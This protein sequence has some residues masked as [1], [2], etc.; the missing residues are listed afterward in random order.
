[1]AGLPRDGALALVGGGQ[2]GHHAAQ[3]RQDSPQVLLE[4]GGLFKLRLCNFKL[5]PFKQETC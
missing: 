1:M 2:Q 3:D 4:G 5:V